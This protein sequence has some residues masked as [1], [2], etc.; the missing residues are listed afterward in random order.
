MQAEYR[1]VQRKSDGETL[2]ITIPNAFAQI[3][4]LKK[5]DTV[6]MT[7]EDNKRIVVQRTAD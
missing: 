2:L 5:S 4:P 3:I 6:K 1:K 7:L